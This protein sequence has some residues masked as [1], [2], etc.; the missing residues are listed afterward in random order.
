MQAV[1]LTP[2]HRSIVQG[3]QDE[4]HFYFTSQQL[5]DCFGLAY[6]TSES[7][8]AIDKILTMNKWLRTLHCEFLRVGF[9]VVAPDFSTLAF[10]YSV[11]ARRHTNNPLEVKEVFALEVPLLALAN[12][13]ASIWIQAFNTKPEL[14]I[15]QVANGKL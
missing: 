3:L 8:E 4:G 9:V 11:Q 2:L 12:E 6:S 7:A 15:I 1:Q 10:T 14:D 5:M 13:T